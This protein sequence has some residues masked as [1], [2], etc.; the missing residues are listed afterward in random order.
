MDFRKRFPLRLGR[1]TVDD[2]VDDEL[3]F[4]LAMRRRELM[5]GGL[6]E[7]Q[8]RKAAVERFGDI[9]RARRECRAI[10]HQR[11]Q[12]MRLLQ[13]LSELRQDAAFSVRQM[14]ASPGFTLVA[15][16]TLA[17][18][19]GATTAIFSAVHAVVLRPLPVP[20]PEKLVMMMSGFRENRHN[21]APRHYLH[22]A[23]QQQAFEAIGAQQIG[24]FT[25]ARE[26]GAERVIGARVTGGFFDVFGVPAALG[27]P[28]N[29]GDD[30]PGREQVVVLSHR[31]WT[32]NF[33]ADPQIV[34]RDI[35]VN[36]RPHTVV[37][38]M[39]PSFDFTSDREELWT[40]IA[41]SPE[42]RDNRGSHFLSVYA[43][44]RSGLTVEQAEAQMP[45]IMARRLETW[46]D[47]SKERT[48]HVVPFMQQFVGEY[49]E[50]LFIL[51]GAV[52]LVLLIACGNVSNLLL[53]RGAAR[54]R[55]LAV[56]S[57]LGAGQ[58]RLV[59]QLFTESLVLGLTAAALGAA[60]AHWFIGM[61][62]A[63]IPPG[64]P[65]LDQARVDAVALGFAIALAVL[66]SIVF[67]L[68]P[69]WRASRTDVNSTIKEA[70]RGAGARQARDIV[71]SALIAAEIAL[72]LVLLVGAGLL[73]RSAVEM[74]RIAPGFDPAGVFAGRIL[75][76]P[77]KYRDA[78]SMMAAARELEAG[79]A[80]IPGARHVA[81][82]NAVPGDRS[83]NNGLLPEGRALLLENVTQ[84]DGIMATP[85]YFRT[86]GIPIVEGRAFNDSDRAGSQ[87]VVVLNRAAAAAM[88]PGENAI[89][90]RLTSANPLGPTTVIG[91]AGDVRLGGPSAPAPPTFYVPYAQMNDEAWS[92]SRSLL[93]VAKTDGDPAAIANEVRRVVSS[94]D[95]AIPLYNVATMEQRM[96][97]TVETARVNTLLLSLLGAVG[98]VLAAVGIYGVI[99]YFTT[100][101]TSEI[102]IR[103]ALGATRRDVVRLVVR[104]AAGPVVSGILLGAAGALLASQALASQL[105]N[106]EATDPVTF[107]GV[108]ATVL[109]IALLAALIPARRAAGMDPTRALA[110]A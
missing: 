106:I 108:A 20:E 28:L 78:E 21:M 69:A 54:A 90:K 93:L 73:I 48:L 27:R 68:V 89:G 74:Q 44:L 60:F 59:R 72:A 53:A 11:E 35:S 41:F 107:G 86:M 76:P 87:L 91:I 50:R 26:E 71:R 84:T 49:R 37:G 105:V 16:L 45:A 81:L 40:P 8:A 39:P 2:E 58:G 65:R 99:S 57:A 43:R 9:T 97:A 92:W 85:A 51:F 33:G 103:M 6:T 62:V 75:L 95:P 4:H 66:A 18:G 25:L 77:A 31:L 15:V 5:A 102:G 55:E 94:V 36:Q 32:R 83:F 100:Q 19:I 1:P 14:I 109:I 24:S 63:F 80:R 67:G 56:R 38:V 10:G 70:G 34:G 17:L 46:P 12:R 88:W 47:E 82:A 79:L 104:Q 98:L 3:D 42:M 64:V 22:A 7:D 110:S 30:Q 61:L 52:T 96:A 13:Y 101:R 23:E 29:A